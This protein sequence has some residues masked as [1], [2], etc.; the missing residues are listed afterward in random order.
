MADCRRK[1]PCGQ[2]HPGCGAHNSAGNPCGK[3]P[4]KGLNVCSTHGGRA[5][6][7]VAKAERARA[8]EDLT[9]QVRRWGGRLDVSPAEALLDLVQSTAY[10][11]AYWEWRIAETTPGGVLATWGETRTEETEQGSKAIAEAVTSMEHR[12]LVKAQDRLAAYSA[13]AIRAGA[14]DKL[15]E[16]AALQA[17]QILDVINR[18]ADAAGV[19]VEV[20]ASAIE[21]ALELT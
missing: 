8:Q 2:P 14:E 10:Q 19:P 4:I 13:T 7:A 6:R 18:F 16:V 11:V 1:P 20:R 17:R 12:E 5:P 21:Q 3:Q 9:N 15:A